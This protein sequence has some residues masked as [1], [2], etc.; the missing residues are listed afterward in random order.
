MKNRTNGPTARGTGTGR[1]NEPDSAGRFRRLG[2][3]PGVPTRPPPSATIRVRP[4]VSS[5]GPRSETVRLPA[6]VPPRRRSGVPP[7]VLRGLSRWG[8]WARGMSR[9]RRSGGPVETR[10][11]GQV[12]DRKRLVRSKA[13]R[14]GAGAAAD[15]VGVLEDGRRTEEALPAASFRH[16][17]AP[18]RLPRPG[19]LG[20]TPP[21]CPRSNS[22]GTERLRR[23]GPR[24]GELRSREAGYDRGRTQRDEAW[25]KGAVFGR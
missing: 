24:P 19:G 17:P 22:E 2:H 15:W 8:P 3:G 14:E 10:A 18:A 25:A 9:G 16:G 20:A 12:E 1:P 6:R 13:E 11:A 23:R 7:K 21:L 4:T 5:Q